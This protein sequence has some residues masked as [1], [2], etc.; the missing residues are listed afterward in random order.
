MPAS[1]APEVALSDTVQQ[2]AADFV[3]TEDGQFLMPDD[4]YG[5]WAYDLQ[6]RPAEERGPLVRELLALS[7]KAFRE[8]GEAAE[9]GISQLCY[10]SG[11]LLVSP[12]VAAELFGAA[13]LDVRAYQNVTGQSG[14]NRPVGQGERP[15]GSTSPL[16][17]RFSTPDE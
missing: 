10:L 7:L 9:I 6:K 5:R 4:V 3:F 2:L 16:G 11:V 8:G 15:A 12:E 1:D 14:S 13:G 17:A